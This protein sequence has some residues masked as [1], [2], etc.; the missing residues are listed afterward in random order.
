MRVKARVNVTRNDVTVQSI[1]LLDRSQAGKSLRYVRHAGGEK[2][3]CVI[4]INVFVFRQL[5]AG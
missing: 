2:K 4:D 5:S 3:I 1:D